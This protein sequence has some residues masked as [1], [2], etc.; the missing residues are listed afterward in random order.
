M[1]STPKYTPTIVLGAY[2]VVANNFGLLGGGGG[3]GEEKRPKKKYYKGRARCPRAPTNV[4]VA[5]PV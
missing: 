3:E 5:A 1:H 2:E 4:E